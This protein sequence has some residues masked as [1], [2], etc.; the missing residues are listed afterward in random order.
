MRE[1]GKYR[2]KPIDKYDKE[3]YGEGFVYG[4]LAVIE[5]VPCI[6]LPGIEYDETAQC[7]QPVIIP[8]DPETVGEYVGLP[9]K[10]GKEI[11]EGDIIKVKSGWYRSIKENQADR[12]D[13]GVKGETLWT[14]EHKTY[15]AQMGFFTF[16]IDRRWFRPLTK[17]RLVNAEAEIIG[18]IHDNPELLK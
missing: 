18:N 8:V 12:F 9:D 1:M 16:G 6:I 10:N 5:Q 7:E 11:Y 14:V 4:G 3:K 15:N 13:N 17:S 2:G